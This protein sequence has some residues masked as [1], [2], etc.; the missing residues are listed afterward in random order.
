MPRCGTIWAEAVL[1]TTGITGKDRADFLEKLYEYFKVQK[2][3]S[4]NVLARHLSE[5]F[6]EQLITSYL[7]LRVREFMRE[8]EL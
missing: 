6:A 3:L 7:Q 5:E 2:A 8:D 1:A 4:L